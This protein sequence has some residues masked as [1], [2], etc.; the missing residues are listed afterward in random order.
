MKVAVAFVSVLFALAGCE[1]NNSKIGSISPPGLPKGPAEAGG[2]GGGGMSSADLRKAVAPLEDRVAQLE[3]FVDAAG[4]AGPA[5][6]VPDAAAINMRLAKLEQHEEALEFLE[7]VYK[8]QP[9]R[10]AKDLC[11]AVDIA[12]NVQLGQTEGP[13]TAPIT[14]V[15][16]WDF[17]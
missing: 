2:G 7:E 6:A 9:K 8:S 16:A 4:K 17:A 3:K 5:G 10:P 12:Q 11:A 1:Q 13:A 14:I 15:E